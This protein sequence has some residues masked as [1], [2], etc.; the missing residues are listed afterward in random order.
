MM[1]LSDS[2]IYL[3]LPRVGRMQWEPGCDEVRMHVRVRDEVVV[4]ERI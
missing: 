2:A 4:G 3:R 1:G